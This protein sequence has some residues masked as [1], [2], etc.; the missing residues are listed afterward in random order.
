L[1]YRGW[2]L[3]AYIEGKDAVM[4]FKTDDGGSIKLL[5]RHH[6]FFIAKPLSHLD[7]LKIS[8]LFERHPLVYSTKIIRRYPNLSRDKRLKV[9]GVKVDEPGDLD[10]VISYGGRLIEIEGIYNTGLIPVQWHLIYADVQPSS[11]CIIDENMGRIRKL[12]RIDDDGLKPPPFTVLEMKIPD[13]V[14]VKKIRLKNDGKEK[15]IEGEERSVLTRLQE[16]IQTSDPDMLVTQSPLSTVRQLQQR[17]KYNSIDLRLGKNSEPLKG[18]V[19]VSSRSFHDMGVAGLSERARFTYAPMGISHEWEAGKTIDSRQCAEAVKLGIMVPPMRGGYAYNSWAWEFIKSDKGG[20]VFSPKPGLHVN[21]AAL[22]FES[23]FPNIIVKKNV[24]YETVIEEGIK[25]DLEGFLGRITEPFLKR[26]IRF[27]HLRDE[28]PKDSQEWTW[29]QQRQST[30]KLFLVVYYGYSGCYANRFANVRV[31]QEINR[32]A[33][34]AMVTALQLAQRRGYEVVYGPFDSIFVKHNDA[35]T[36]DFDELAKEIS[37]ET[38]LPM[39]LDRHFKYLVLLNKTTDPI[40]TAANRYYGKLVDGSPFYRGIEMRRHDTPVYI[41]KVQEEMINALFEPDNPKLVL[42][43]GLVKAQRIAGKAISSI[44]RGK[45]DP[46]EL[47]ISK[48]LRK[49]LEDYSAKQPHIVAAMLGGMEEMS[50]YILVNTESNNPFMRVMPES[51]IDEGHRT[52]DRR[53]YAAMMRRAA[54]NILRPFVP[55]EKNIGKPLFRES[56]LDAYL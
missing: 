9:I 25:Q 24:S 23:M 46:R 42:K 41:H 36:R 7:P 35:D 19:L 27:K 3:D 8:W 30:L 28:Y 15:T 40:V 26:R 16:E 14:Q 51:M 54:W 13:L 18:R 17:A 37:D 11:K 32:Q 4:W 33:R 22:D 20:M 49:D 31:F 34:K 39:R 44:R 56:D 10:R 12:T 21:V 53:K 1:R 43:D 52:Y 5:D 48:R 6:P 47:V 38:N 29:C 45:V 55:E 2:L 50:R